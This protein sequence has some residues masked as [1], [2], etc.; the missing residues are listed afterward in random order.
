[1]VRITRPCVEADAVRL[2]SSRRMLWSP[3]IPLAIGIVCAVTVGRGRAFHEGICLVGGALFALLVLWQVWYLGFV[4][5]GRLMIRNPLWRVVDLEELSRVE[6]FPGGANGPVLRLVDRG[7]AKCLFART[8]LSRNDWAVVC[9]LLQ[10]YIDRD[11]VS[12]RGPVLRILNASGV[13][14][15][16]KLG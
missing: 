4:D 1:M 8:N 10:S 13:A 2:G 16:S 6:G 15:A 7:G 12:H 11:G 9:Q 14:S 3:L 5:K